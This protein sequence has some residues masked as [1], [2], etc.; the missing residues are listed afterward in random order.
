[1]IEHIK[2]FVYTIIKPTDEEWNGF[3]D[4][5]KTKNLKAGDILLSSGEVCNDIHFVTKGVMRLYYEK[6]GEEINTYFAFQNKFMS[7]YQ[8]FLSREPSKY[9]IQAMEDCTIVS[10]SY[11]D[12]QHGFNNFNAWNTFGRIIAEQFFLKQQKRVE[13]FLFL[14]AEE[15]YLELLKTYPDIFE[16]IPL[17]H[18]ASYLGIKGPSLSRIRKSL[19]KAK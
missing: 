16:R 7:S 2:T 8:S 11:E 19:V 13:S 12:V 15:R 10:L 5:L 6:D 3:A 18:I 4:R 17:Y 9:C 1:M 14:S